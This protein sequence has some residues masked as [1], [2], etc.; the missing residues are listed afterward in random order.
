MEIEY[1]LNEI[2]TIAQQLWEQY[3]SYKV[4]AFYATMGS[5]KTTFINALCKFL[6]VQDIVSS[7]TFSI[8]NQ[9]CSNA[10]QQ[11]LY[12]IDAYR[13]KD[14]QEAIDSGVEDALYSNDLCLVEW[15]SIIESLLPKPYLM[16]KLQAIN[17]EKRKLKIEV[18]P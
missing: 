10:L 8:I 12:H 5:G 1:R 9:Y 4:W 3:K 14:E 17:E 15:P 6:Q 13:L 2:N 18:V 11:N 16:I 7:P